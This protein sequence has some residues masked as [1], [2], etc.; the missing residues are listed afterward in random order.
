MDG[1]HGYI[2]LVLLLAF[3]LLAQDRLQITNGDV[4]SAG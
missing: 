2:Q 1:H 3:T 4:P